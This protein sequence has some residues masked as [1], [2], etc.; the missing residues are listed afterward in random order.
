VE[1]VCRRHTDMSAAVQVATYLL[2]G[3]SIAISGGLL[4][5]P[6]AAADRVLA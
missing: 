2:P 4:N 1:I 3:A 6:A 5:L